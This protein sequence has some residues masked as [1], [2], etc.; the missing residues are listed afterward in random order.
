MRTGGEPLEA[1]SGQVLVLHHFRVG[2]RHFTVLAKRDVA[3]HRLEGV[4]AQ[5]VGELVLV[6]ALGG[7]DRIGQHLHISISPRGEVIACGDHTAPLPA[8]AATDDASEVRCG[9]GIH[10]ADSPLNARHTGALRRG[11]LMRHHK[12]KA[13]RY[14]GAVSWMIGPPIVVWLVGRT[15]LDPAAVRDVVLMVPAARH[16]TP[17]ALDATTEPMAVTFDV[18]CTKLSLRTTSVTPSRTSE[19]TCRTKTTAPTCLRSFA[20]PGRCGD[21]NR[22]RCRTN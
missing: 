13:E 2:L 22:T 16:I 14:A 1:V 11:L 7:F 20:P 19:D 18:P 17:L 15:F 21:S 9:K 3:H 6:E 12:D 4:A 5:P 8:R 10:G